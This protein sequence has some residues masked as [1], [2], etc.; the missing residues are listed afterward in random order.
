VSL[1]T[2]RGYRAAGVNRVSFGVQSLNDRHL[3]TLGRI[4]SA[5]E[6]VTAVDL[7]R[8]AG[9][10]AIN[11]DFI[12]GVPGQT[13]AEWEAD[14]HGALA[15][16]PGHVSAYSLTYEEGTAFHAWRAAGRLVPAREED[17]IDMFR[18]A[19]ALLGGAGYEAYEISNYARPGRACRHNLA[20]WRRRPYLGVG[21]GAHSFAATPGYGRRWSAERQPERYMAAVELQG[22]ATAG[23]EECSR[24]QA[25]GEFMFLGLR[26][27]A[28]IAAD[29]FARA[30]GVPPEAAYAALPG[31]IAGGHLERTDGRLRLT[32]AGLLVGDSVFTAFL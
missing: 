19:R 12:F 21:A 10:E 13:V 16:D 6:A 25:M 5:A 31:L 9:F 27:A 8:R 1:E 14:L 11:T 7:A 3:A 17:E 20:Y 4:H 24:E 30:F 18:L 29:D 32:P 26:L 23:V 2:L 22:H 15:L 28:G